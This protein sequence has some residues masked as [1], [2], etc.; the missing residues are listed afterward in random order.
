[1]LSGPSSNEVTEDVGRAWSNA[2]NVALR[3]DIAAA[4]LPEASQ[5]TDDRRR[6]RLRPYV[7]ALLSDVNGDAARLLLTAQACGARADF[8]DSYAVPAGSRA[9]RFVGKSRAVGPT[10]AGYVGGCFT[11]QDQSEQASS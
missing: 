7:T 1:M 6:E 3:A 9:A 10:R 4:G 5:L 8:D 2:V 11:N